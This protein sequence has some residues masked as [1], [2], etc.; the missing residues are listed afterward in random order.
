MSSAMDSLLDTGV[1][2]FNY[3]A[4]KFAIEPADSEHNY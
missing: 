1:S 3:F 2:I 4:I